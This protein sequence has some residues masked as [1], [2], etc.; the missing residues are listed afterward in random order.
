MAHTDE[1]KRNSVYVLLC[2]F[3]FAGYLIW[4]HIFAL[5]MDNVPLVNTGGVMSKELV[6]RNIS[7]LIGLVCIALYGFSN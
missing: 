1:I 7:Q 6:I 4:T 2:I 5:P 3:G